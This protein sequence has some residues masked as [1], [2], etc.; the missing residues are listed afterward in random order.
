MRITRCD[1]REGSQLRTVNI[2]TGY[3]KNADGSCLIEMGGTRV[4]CSASIEDGAP[5][6]AKAKGHG[7]LTAEY[8]M[9]PASTG[10]RKSRERLKQDGRSTEIQ[11][12]IGRSLRQAV[13]LRALGDTT[14]TIDCD[15][16]D[17][18]GGT[19]CAAITGG[20]VALAIACGKRLQSGK[21][22]SSPIAAQ[23]AAVSVG[24]VD[25]AP[26]LD[27]CYCEDSSAQ[28]DMN[29]IMN[30]KDGFIE[31]QGTG[32]G[33][34]FGRD[35]LDALTA[36]GESGIRQLMRA[37]RQALISANCPCAL[38]AGVAVLASRNS[39][40]A[41][42][43]TALLDGRL[44]LVT[45]D[46][47]GFTGELTEDGQ[48]FQE[49]ARLKAEAVR[50]LCSLPALAD[51]SGLC[52]EALGGA[53]GIYSARYAGSHG[54]DDTNNQ[55]LLQNLSGVAQ[56]RA[57]KFVCAL[58][59]AAPGADTLAVTG[60]LAGE[61]GLTPSG[62]GGFG[63]DPLFRVNGVSLADMCDSEKNRISHR[64]AAVKS[65]AAALGGPEC[66]LASV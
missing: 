18:D 24:L 38:P 11:R 52:V 43:L 21:W 7:W 56:P 27:L 30:H 58:A 33:R 39:G 25:D 40:K 32:E 60:E 50:D 36:L 12:L 2:I 6:F 17:A 62:R 16:L 65:L 61:I 5:P 51:D 49:N 48:T 41:R 47:I 31:I 34:A 59:L 4:I 66:A 3:Q 35:E 23:V 53:P 15:V 55:L 63:Y 20:Y 14:I 64:A 22:Q 46:D 8:A 1:G 54:N 29:I 26:A 37:Q 44:R 45:L 10:Q 42:E 19:R 28:A 9:L 57:A 13:D